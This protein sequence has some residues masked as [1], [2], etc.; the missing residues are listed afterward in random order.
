MI[1]CPAPVGRLLLATGNAGKIAELRALLSARP[2]LMG[3]RLATPGDL[4]LPPPEVDEAGET[5][6]Q[7]ARL[8][9]AAWAR[10]SGLPALADDSGLCVD[11]LGGEPGV[12]SARWAGPTDADRNDALLR[13]LAGVPPAERTARFVCAACA[14]TP[15]GAV[16]EAEGVCRGVITGAPRGAGGFGYDPLF[17]VAESGMTLAE[18]APEWKNRISHRAQALALMAPQLARLLGT[19]RAESW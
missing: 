16:A 6:A 18:M 13:R 12:I 7:N 3:V 8:K 4:P 1:D 14:A 9:A 2:E 10:W 19:F 11:G 15:E 5:F 17:L